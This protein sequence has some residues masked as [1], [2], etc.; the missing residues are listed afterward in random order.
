MG[1]GGFWGL[2]RRTKE[3]HVVEYIREPVRNVIKFSLAY[4]GGGF[5]RVGDFGEDIPGDSCSE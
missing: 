5:V 4:Q 2:W 3:G 1:A